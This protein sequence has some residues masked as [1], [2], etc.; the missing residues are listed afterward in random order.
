MQTVLLNGYNPVNV[1]WSNKVLYI[2]L[3]FLTYFNMCSSKTTST[4][5]GYLYDNYGTQKGKFFSL[6]LVK[7]GTSSEI[8]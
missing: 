2:K 3:A 4:E 7:K 8:S 5:I 1:P 6:I